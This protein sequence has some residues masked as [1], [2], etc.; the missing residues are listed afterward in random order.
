M[1]RLGKKPIIIPKGV[2]VFIEG[3]AIKVEGPKG[4]IAK[5]IPGRMKF[6]ILGNDAPDVSNESCVTISDNNQIVIERPSDEKTDKS[7]HG[8]SRKIVLNMIEGVVKGFEKQLE[9]TGLGY[10]ATATKEG[11]T[12]EKV[13]THPV[14]VPVPEEIKIEVKD[15]KVIVRGTDKELVG[16]VA[17][18]IRN[19]KPVEPYKGKGIKYVGEHVRRKAGKAVVKTAGA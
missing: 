14:M 2:K 6:K 12:L 8:L 3:N 17:S 4:K 5:N 10:R 7:L 13:Y 9:V 15:G 16:K 19:V 18:D 11:L 1:S